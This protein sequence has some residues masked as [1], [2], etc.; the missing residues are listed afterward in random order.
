[1]FQ[2]PPSLAFFQC[3]SVR[4]MLSPPENPEQDHPGSFL[5]FRVQ[6]IESVHRTL[7][8]KGVKFVD[9]PHRVH[10]AADYDLWMAFFHDPDLNPMALMEEK[11][12]PPRKA[13]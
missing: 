13:S 3:G 9:A 5:Y 2:A 4:L 12:K 7:A 10:E 6:D 1:L 8:G 11:P